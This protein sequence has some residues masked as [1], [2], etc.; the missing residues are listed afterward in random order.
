VA[1]R[2]DLTRLPTRYPVSYPDEAFRR[3]RALLLAD[4]KRHGRPLPFAHSWIAATALHYQV[5]RVTPNPRDF[6]GIGE[7]M[8]ISE[9]P[10]PTS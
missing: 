2:A 5:A 4:A 8:V 3:C 6:Q 7:L 9:V 10:V 1:H